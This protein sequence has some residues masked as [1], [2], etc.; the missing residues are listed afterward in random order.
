MEKVGTFLD[1][2]SLTTINIAQAIATGTSIQATV[3]A[4][5]TILLDIRGILSSDPNFDAAIPKGLTRALD[6]I[7]DFPRERKSK[8]SKKSRKRAKKGKKS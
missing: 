2:H 4:E 5:M 3:E 6:S 8:K 1:M 7:I